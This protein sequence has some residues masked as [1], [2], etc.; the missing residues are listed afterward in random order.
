MTSKQSR[1]EEQNTE[2]NNARFKIDTQVQEINYLRFTV[3][4]QNQEIINLKDIIDDQDQEINSL[5]ETIHYHSAGHNGGNPYPVHHN[6]HG[7]C[8]CQQCSPFY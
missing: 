6:F 8:Q 3:E 4:S 2:I 7:H 1:I 5:R